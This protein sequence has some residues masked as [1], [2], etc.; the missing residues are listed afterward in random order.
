VRKRSCFEAISTFMIKI[1]FKKE[2][3][4]MSMCFRSAFLSLRV[5]LSLCVLFASIHFSSS[6][7]ESY[8]F[9]QKNAL[10]FWS[11]RKLMNS[12][13][14]RA[15]W[16][17]TMMTKNR[18]WITTIVRI[19]F[20]VVVYQLIVVVSRVLSATNVLDRRSRVSR[21]VLNSCI[22]IFLSNSSQISIRFRIV[23]YQL[24]DVRVVLRVDEISTKTFMKERAILQ[25]FLIVW[26][27]ERNDW[28]NADEI[29][30]KAIRAHEKKLFFMKNIANSFSI[31]VK[32][33]ILEMHDL[34]LNFEKK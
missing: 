20:D 10:R 28:K 25:F 16:W 14:T 6:S 23:V 11:F 17:T 29:D 13:A 21:Y 12:R 30:K 18:T 3:K 4:F 31:L 19:V 8:A 26:D 1:A 24:S 9:R 5:F 2:L 34:N 15:T 22:D 32:W 7:L 33:K 27:R